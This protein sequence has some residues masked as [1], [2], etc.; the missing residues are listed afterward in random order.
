MQEVIGYLG[1]ESYD[2]ILLQARL[3]RELGENVGLLDCSY[4]KSLAYAIPGLMESASDFIEFAGSIACTSD[5]GIPDVLRNCGVIIIYAGRN[6][7]AA[8]INDLT[9]VRFVTD[10]QKHNIEFIKSCKLEDGT[11]VQV[12]LREKIES[13]IK[14]DF[15]LN[16]LHEFEIKSEDVFSLEDTQLDL[17]NRVTLQYGALKKMKRISSEM[18]EFI[19]N[20]VTGK[21]D[22]KEVKQ[23]LKRIRR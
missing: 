21:Y 16:E 23:V 20:T 8:C 6:C 5:S 11:S 17:E 13:K 14:S 15:I 22:E 2:I 4:D 3:L 9:A 19:G 7:T 18:L 1:I 12:I 10:F